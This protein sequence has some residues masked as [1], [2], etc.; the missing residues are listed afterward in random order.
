MILLLH[1]INYDY[2]FCNLRR[3]YK[4][5]QGSNFLSLSPVLLVTSVLIPKLNLQ[6]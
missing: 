5:T 3:N 2:N 6:L 4:V 1:E